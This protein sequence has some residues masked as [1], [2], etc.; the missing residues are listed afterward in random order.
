M[1]RKPA[2]SNDSSGEKHFS[3]PVH[4]EDNVFIYILYEMSS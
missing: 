4:G 2:K 3:T 1:G